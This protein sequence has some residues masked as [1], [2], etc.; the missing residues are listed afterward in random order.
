MSHS[1][2]TAPIAWCAPA[3]SRRAAAG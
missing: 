1:G 2:E 3:P